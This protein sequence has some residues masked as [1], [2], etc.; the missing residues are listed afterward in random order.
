MGVWTALSLVDVES[1]G[2]GGGSIAWIDARGMLRVGPRSAGAEPGPACYRRG[3]MEPTVTDALLVLGYVEPA[4][5][6]GGD[7]ALDE[8][9]AFEACERVG[10]PLGLDARDAAW[11]IRQLALAGMIKGSARGWRRAASIRARTRCSATAVAARCSRRASPPRSARPASS[12]PNWRRCCRRSAP[13]RP[14]CAAN[15]SRPCSRTS[16]SMHASSRKTRRSCAPASSTTSRL[17]GSR[18]QTGRSPSRP[19]SVS[20]VRCG[21]SRSRCPTARSVTRRWWRSSTRF[22]TSTGSGTAG[23]R[24]CSTRRSSSSACARSERGGR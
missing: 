9:A 16:P 10:K 8:D 24:S 13:R 1:I 2:A 23:V 21:R 6:L 12:F 17:T 18:T 7:M 3:G 4:R 11:G 19:I 5:F 14:M 15:G 20:N 22:V